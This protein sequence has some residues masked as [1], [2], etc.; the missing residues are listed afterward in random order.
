MHI[1]VNTL[2]KVL[3]ID[4]NVIIYNISLYL[5]NIYI[6]NKNIN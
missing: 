5:Y 2:N 1:L 4:T 3:N 6:N